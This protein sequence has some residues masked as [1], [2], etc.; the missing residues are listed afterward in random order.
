MRHNGPG[1]TADIGVIDRRIGPVCLHR[2]DVEAVAVDQHLGDARPRLVELGGAVRRLAEH[3]DAAVAKALDEIAKLVQI[4][5]WLGGFG[6]E[7]ADAIMD[8]E[9]ALR[10]D[11]KPRGVAGRLGIE[12]RL[13]LTLGLGPAFLPDQRHEGY[14]AEIFLLEAILAGAALA[15]QRLEPEL[16]YGHDQ[17][18][19]DREL[20]LQRVGDMR[21]AGGDDDGLERRLLG[22][23]LGAVGADDFGIGVAEPLQPGG[24][25]LRQRRVSL[26]G[27]H[28]VGHAAHDRRGVARSG[29]D[30]EHRVAWL[31]LGKLDHA[32]DDIRLRDG[33]ARLDGQRRILV[34]ELLEMLRHEGLARHRAHGFK[35]ERIVNAARLE[36]PLDHDGTVAGIGAVEDFGA[37]QD[38]DDKLAGRHW[39][40]P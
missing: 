26:D 32:G 13:P 23:A 29:A 21:T 8:G 27:E 5:E 28:L 40:Q 18:A 7:L 10:R 34:D 6:H 31:D 37:L 2:D 15:D 38:H 39:F 22:Q 4:A 36:M 3:D 20:P 9:R 25:E 24:G 19:A 16:A 30:L 35:Q 12:F 17:A 33:L 14:G 1:Q 11:E